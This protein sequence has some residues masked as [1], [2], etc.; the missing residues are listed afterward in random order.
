M[1]ARDEIAI[2]VVLARP[3]RQFIVHL[4]VPPGTT[5]GEAVGQSALRD[6]LLVSE[7]ALSSYAI[8]G[9]VVPLSRRVASG[10]RIDILRPLRVD[11]KERRRTQAARERPKRR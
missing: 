4:S 11:P 2:S 10:D 3:E 5:V 7:R 6:K 9:Q 8:Y 1:A